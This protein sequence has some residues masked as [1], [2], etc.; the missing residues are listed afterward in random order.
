MSK[1]VEHL[2]INFLKKFFF[3]NKRKAIPI[4][5]GRF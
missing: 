4:S 3:L 2:K 5:G 1:G